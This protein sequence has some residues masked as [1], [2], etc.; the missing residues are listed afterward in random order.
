MYVL[1]CPVVGVRG[2][3]RS[4]CPSFNCIQSSER[5][6][7]S[8]L[9]AGPTTSIASGLNGAK[10]GSCWTH[11]CLDVVHSSLDPRQICPDNYPPR[12]QQLVS[13]PLCVCVCSVHGLGVDKSSTARLDANQVFIVKCVRVRKE[14]KGRYATIIKSTQVRLFR[15]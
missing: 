2:G 11:M 10:L 13:V 6:F 12:K 1:G 3:S 4:W 5:M 8:T 9:S 7:G 15:F 14:S